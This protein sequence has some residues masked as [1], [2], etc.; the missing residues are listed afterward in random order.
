M[1]ILFKHFI[2]IIL[3]IFVLFI[4]NW[5]GISCPVKQVLKV[6]CPACGMTRSFIALT[7][8]DFKTSFFYN[9]MTIPLI[10]ALFF[11]FHKKLFKRQKLIDILL[12]AISVMIFLLYLYRLSRFS[13]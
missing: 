4:Y 3:I 10:I 5:L 6:P 2:F 11:G 1:K 7:R 8:L 13:T 12:I 9:P